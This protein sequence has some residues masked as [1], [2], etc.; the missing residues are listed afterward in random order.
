MY[1]LRS[2]Y[3]NVEE[4]VSNEETNKKFKPVF[5]RSSASQD[6]NANAMSLEALYCVLAFKL[7]CSIKLFLTYCLQNIW[8]TAM[9]S[10][11]KKK[12]ASSNISKCHTQSRFDDRKTFYFL[13]H[14]KLTL[15][16]GFELWISAALKFDMH[17]DLLVMLMRLV[18][19]LV[20]YMYLCICGWKT[21]S[22]QRTYHLP[23][24]ATIEI[25][26]E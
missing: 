10:A 1:L 9:Y 3:Q 12:T 11:H 25:R 5:F 7:K 6:C 26:V 18:I 23:V 4:T 14:S 20:A 24:T 2:S 17:E 22:Q 15:I 8:Y 19:A 13:H 16:Q 21:A